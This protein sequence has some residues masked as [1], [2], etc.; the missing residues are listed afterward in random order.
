MFTVNGAAYGDSYAVTWDNGQL[1]GTPL[2]VSMLTEQVGDTVVVPPTGPVYELT[3]TDPKSVI[4]ALLD[5]TTV[6][7]IT[8][9]APVVV[10]PVEEGVVY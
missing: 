10:P 3:L 6:D 9:D 7:S 5:L 4:A 1:S 8:G 2:I